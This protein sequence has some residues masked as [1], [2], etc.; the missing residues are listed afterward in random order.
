MSNLG[1]RF[2]S[3]PR[4]NKVIKKLSSV[5]LSVFWPAGWVGRVPKSQAWQGLY[6]ALVLLI[7]VLPM[8]RSLLQ[9]PQQVTT[10]CV[11]EGLS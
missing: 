6:K 4:Q 11:L 7:Y 1:K 5:K 10:H 2:H 9:H 8:H 3:K